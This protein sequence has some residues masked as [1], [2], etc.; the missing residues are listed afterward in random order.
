MLLRWQS[1][2]ATTVLPHTDRCHRRAFSCTHTAQSNSSICLPAWSHAQY[3]ACAVSCPQAL[4]SLPPSRHRQNA[5]AAAPRHTKTRSRCTRASAPCGVCGARIAMHRVCMH[6]V[7]HAPFGGGEGGSTDGTRTGTRAGPASNRPHRH[8]RDELPMGDATRSLRACVRH[9]TA[10]RMRAAVIA[11]ATHTQGIAS[12]HTRQS[13]QS[14]AN[15]NGWRERGHRGHRHSTHRY[16]SSPG[17]RVPTGAHWKYTCAH[18]RAATNTQTRV[19]MHACGK[20]D[21]HSNP[22]LQQ[23]LCACALKQQAGAKTVLAAAR[24]P[25]GRPQPPEGSLGHAK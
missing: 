25:A 9:G 14:H 3:T 8:Q 7:T 18:A 16:P 23:P 1:H 10:R 21:H 5:R 4:D 22:G 11:C 17:C 19:R 6:R 24:S 2:N 20:A 12:Q 13:T 15:N